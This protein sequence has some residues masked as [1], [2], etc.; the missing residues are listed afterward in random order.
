MLPPLTRS[1][2][3]YPLRA[4]AKAANVQVPW[5]LPKRKSRS[6]YSRG[7]Q[8]AIQATS[9]TIPVLFD[10]KQEEP[11]RCPNFHWNS[12][13]SA[14][15]KNDLFCFLFC[16]LF[17]VFHIVVHEWFGVVSDSY[18]YL[19]RRCTRKTLT[20]GELV[21]L[22]PL[23]LVISAANLRSYRQLGDYFC[24]RFPSNE[25]IHQTICTGG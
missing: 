5:Y 8:L 24:R 12:A 6:S 19:E 18:E 2:L 11:I 21:R 20:L 13:H 15:S 7:K 14:G 25:F 10:S 17:F 22:L 16:F 9:R 23:W 3:R 1:S 4:G